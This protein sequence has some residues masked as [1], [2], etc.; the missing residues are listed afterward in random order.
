MKGKSTVLLIEEDP[1][2]CASLQRIL[3]E[4]NC[5]VIFVHDMEEACDMAISK[6]LDL[7]I[8]GYISPGNKV[9]ELYRWFRKCSF[10]QDTPLIILEASKEKLEHEGWDKDKSMMIDAEEVLN[11]SATPERLIDKLNTLLGAQTEKIKVLIADD[12]AMVREGIKNLLNL[13]EDISI[14]GEAINGKEAL[15]KA[16]EF[17]PDVVLMDIVMPKKSGIEAAKS[18]LREC[19]EKVKIVM[20]SQY[21]DE[22]I[23]SASLEA[24]AIGFVSKKGLSEQLLETIR[25]AKKGEKMG[26]QKRKKCELE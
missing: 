12:H 24:G 20:L 17:L 1:N 11:K 8:L 14:V 16:L 3:E 6:D 19:N 10:L 13:Q 9:Y 23:L 18:I 25:G 15:E 22:Q 2:Y 21:D 4:N 26:W 7:V 5:R